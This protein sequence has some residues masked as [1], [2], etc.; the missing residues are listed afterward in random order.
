MGEVVAFAQDTFSDTNGTAITAHT[1]DSGGAWFQLAAGA[2]AG[3]VQ[4]ARAYGGSTRSYF[5]TDDA[6]PS[7]DYSVSADL[8]YTGSSGSTNNCGVI[9][10]ASLAAQNLYIL[11]RNNTGIELSKF[12]T[13][14]PSNIATVTRA[15]EDCNLELVLTGTTLEAF[16]IIASTGQYVTPAGG[17]Q[18]SRVACIS[19]TDGSHS[20]AGRVGIALGNSGATTRIHLDNFEA[21]LPGTTSTRSETST[22]TLSQVVAD[23]FVAGNA[24][25]LSDTLGFVQSVGSVNFSDRQI[26]ENDL[27]LTQDLWSPSHPP[28]NNTLNLLSV[29]VGGL[30]PVPDLEQSLSLSS[31]ASVV[32]GVPHASPWGVGAIE[33]TLSFSASAERQILPVGSSTL[34]FTQEAIASYGLD[35]EITFAQSVS[36]GVNR[37]IESEIAFVSTVS[38]GTSEWLRSVTGTMALTSA[39]NAW[40][41]DDKCARRNSAAGVSATAGTLT[42]RSKNGQYSVV[43][44]NPETDN[45]RRTAYDRVVRETRGGKLIVFRDTSWNTVQTLLFTIVAMKRTMITDLQTFFLNTLGQEITLVDWLGEEWSGV[46]T[47]PDE[48]FTEDREGWWTFAFEF[49]GSK[50]SGSSGSQYLNLTSE[51]TQV[52]V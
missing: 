15:Y 30:F 37:P 50:V 32:F 7:A 19:V 34:V 9:A 6:P 13:G 5:Y 12:V 23:T 41:G 46:V 49:E 42:L 2:G 21:S 3:F 4:T 24:N 51:A 25:H 43:L 48:T 52:V 29:A 27:G 10:R 45:I 39:S 22:M 8:F 11:L 20:A 35:S 44:R 33:Q 47:K 14:T 16:V 26:P 38:R 31:N 18:V 36:G 28:A 1:L 40:N 17:S